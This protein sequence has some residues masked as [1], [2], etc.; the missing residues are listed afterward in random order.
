MPAN[1]TIIEVAPDDLR[2]NP[3]IAALRAE[4]D[5]R[6]PEEIQFEHPAVKEAARFL[7]VL[8]D[9]V[10]AGCCALQPLGV[11]E[12]EL[13]RMY[14]DPRH[15][16]QRIAHHLMAEVE[17]LAARIGIRH[18]RLETGVRQ[19]E[20]ITVYERAGFTPIPNYPP[21]D[22][23]DMSICYAKTL[24]PA[25]AGKDRTAPSQHGSDS[26]RILTWP[27]VC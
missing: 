1:L 12:G 3:L 14:V 11:G 8:V 10:S 25:L 19:P 7:L 17:A 27:V 26:H 2:L 21:Y 5:A 18:V 16:G 22:Q 15:R 4:L 6:Y 13:K 23:W 24:S 9:D 20:A